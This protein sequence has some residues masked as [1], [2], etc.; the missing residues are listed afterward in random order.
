[1][2]DRLGIF[3]NRGRLRAHFTIFAKKRKEVLGEGRH[4][5]FSNG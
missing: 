5:L 4:D 1:L 2:F 3:L